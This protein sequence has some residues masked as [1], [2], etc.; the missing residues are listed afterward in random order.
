MIL[1][2]VLIA[3][4]SWMNWTNAEQSFNAYRDELM[5][6]NAALVAVS[7]EWWPDYL[8]QTSP[9]F[10]SKELGSCS[11]NLMKD[12]DYFGSIEL[13]IYGSSKHWIGQ[14]PF[15]NGIAEVFFSP[16]TL[17]TTCQM[18][19]FEDEFTRERRVELAM[20][21]IYPTCASGFHEQLSN[22]L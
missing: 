17:E 2:G 15:W 21:E 18:R 19:I 22:S 6:A 5:C 14:R 11:Y 9:V 8:D 20:P 3:S 10:L 12:G 7:S 4:W 1:G 13:N 16:R